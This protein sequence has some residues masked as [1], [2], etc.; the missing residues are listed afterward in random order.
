[1]IGGRLILLQAYKQR[2]GNPNTQD[3]IKVNYQGSLINVN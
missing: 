3:L 1:M 2:K